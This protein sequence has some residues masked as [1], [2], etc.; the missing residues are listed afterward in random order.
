MAKES[1]G[2]IYKLLNSIKS[3]VSSVSTILAKVN[4]LAST[5]TEVNNK[6]YNIGLKLNGQTK[7]IET[8]TL[9]N[10][11]NRY[12]R[13]DGKGVA[14]VICRSSGSSI[15]AV[16]AV[17]IDYTTVAPNFFRKSAHNEYF[18]EIPFDSTVYFWYS[19]QT[20]SYTCYADILVQYD[21]E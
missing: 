7:T 10:T 6:C 8:V 9:S 15:P 20:Y 11:S 4:A 19:D 1:N 17:E 14:Y 5:L 16:P 2:K 18:W 13:F 21:K 12:A 3:S